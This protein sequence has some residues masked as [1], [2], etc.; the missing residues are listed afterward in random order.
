MI[1]TKT[2]SL[3]YELNKINIAQT[4][5]IN[6][7]DSKLLI[8]NTKEIIKFKELINILPKK[9]VL[10]LNKSAVKD[11]R[12]KTIKKITGGKI[13]IFILNKISYNICE[14]LLSFSGTKKIGSFIDTEHFKFK[15]ID[16]YNGIYLIKTNSRINKIIKNYGST[17]LPPYIKDNKS[18][19]KNYK[20]DYTKGGFSLAASTA[21]LHFNNKILDKYRRKGIVVKFL[22]LDIGL[23]TFKPINSKYINDHKIHEEKYSMLK[24]DY[25]HILKLKEKGYVIYSVGTTVLRSLE[26]IALSGKYKG[27][28]DL[29]IT[30]GFRFKIVDY[31]ITNFHAPKSTLLSIVLTIY[32]KNWKELYM[33]AQKKKMKFLSFGDGVLFKINE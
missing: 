2:D 7:D 33:Y 5:Y 13:E 18:Q 32:G 27:V 11:V 23:G 10:V 9:S 31:L 14:C 25:N 24:K 1:K 26:T 12:I 8:A 20:S 3:N 30:P 21:G 6:P 29:Y 16:K 19:Y 22:N 17:P 28:T 15:I 4:R